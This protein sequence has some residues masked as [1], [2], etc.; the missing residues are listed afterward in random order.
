MQSTSRALEVQEKDIQQAIGD[1]LMVCGF[2]VQSTTAHRQ[3]AASGVSLG[4]PDLLIYH[5]L[6]PC[7]CLGLEV[8]RN[9][10]ARRRS[11]QV[12]MVA[13]GHYEFVWTVEMAARAAEKWFRTYCPVPTEHSLTLSRLKTVIAETARR[14]Q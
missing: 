13:A 12:K 10:R 11:D 9:E 6:V 1:A 8:K 7:C 14:S 3:K 2:V 5:P 4:V